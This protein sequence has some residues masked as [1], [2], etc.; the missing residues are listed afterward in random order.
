MRAI[1]DQGQRTELEPDAGGGVAD[2]LSGE[3]AVDGEALA[4]TS[5]SGHTRVGTHDGTSDEELEDVTTISDVIEV[6]TDL[7]AV[8]GAG[9][10][11][12][13]YVTVHGTSGD[14]HAMRTIVVEVADDG[15]LGERKTGRIG[16]VRTIVDHRDSP[17]GKC[18]GLRH[19]RPDRKS[20]AHRFFH[21]SAVD[22]ARRLNTFTLEHEEL[23]G[24]RPSP[25]FAFDIEL[26]HLAE[27]YELSLDNDCILW[28]VPDA[29]RRWLADPSRE[30]FAMV[31]DAVKKVECK[32]CGSHHL[33]RRPKTER[34]ARHA[35][36]TL[37]H[38]D[39]GA[40]N[41]TVEE[42]QA[43]WLVTSVMAPVGSRAIA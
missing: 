37:R 8:G 22:F 10:G 42:V 1:P 6:I 3:V 38:R 33:Y 30:V 40:P 26:F 21:G 20:K 15:S 43:A 12:A 13:D 7:S 28:D 36:R 18:G 24:H 23:F 9:Y 32:T 5:P 39:E 17:P 25:G 16:K 27:R 34:D 11:A 14:G 29:M 2:G 41:A 35:G 4:Q 19:P 31:G